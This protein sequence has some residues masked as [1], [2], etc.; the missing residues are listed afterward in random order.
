M[1]VPRKLAVISLLLV[2]SACVR[3]IP[4]GTPP[5]PVLP[6]RPVPVPSA[7]PVPGSAALLGLHGGPSVASLNLADSDARGGLTAFRSSCPKLLARTDN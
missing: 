3:V 1:S 5:V 4:G 2:L 7:S 6:P